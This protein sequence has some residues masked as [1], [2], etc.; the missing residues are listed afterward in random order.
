[1]VSEEVGND[2]KITYVSLQ[3]ASLATRLTSL[4]GICKW[5]LRTVTE[6]CGDLKVLRLRPDSSTPEIVDLRPLL[7][8]LEFLEI[9]ISHY[10][11]V[12]GLLRQPW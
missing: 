10:A 8:S 9:S 1:V 5:D 4:S 6:E 11:D 7:G 12:N 3:R 2:H